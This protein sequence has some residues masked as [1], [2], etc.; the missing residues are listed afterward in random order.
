MSM[1]G[2]SSQTPQTTRA[3][4]SPG[5]PARRSPR[6]D[7]SDV[8]QAGED[9]EGDQT[10]PE[11]DQGV[12]AQRM[13]PRRDEAGR[14]RLPRHMPPMYVASSTARDTAVEPTTSWSIWNQTTS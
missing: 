12:N 10:D 2:G 5:S 6:R 14:S 8:R 4:R 1:V 3:R 7:R 11:F 13:A 9:Q